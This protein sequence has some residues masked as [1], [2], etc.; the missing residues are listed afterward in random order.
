MSKPMTASRE[1]VPRWKQL[2]ESAIFTTNFDA[3][4]RHIQEAQNAVMDHIE[5]TFQTASDS[6][7]QTLINA[8][9]SLR[10][11]RRLLQTP[12]FEIEA[13]IRKQSDA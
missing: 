10:E 7:R 5:D 2:V 4:A 1:V 8:M 6:E 9:N 3:L 13:H 11:L 12:D